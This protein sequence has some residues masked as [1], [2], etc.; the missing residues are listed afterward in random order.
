MAD[1]IEGGAR[2]LHRK[3]ARE[4]AGFARG[5]ESEVMSIAYVSGLSQKLVKRCRGGVSTARFECEA[6]LSEASA[7]GIYIWRA[8]GAMASMR[9]ACS[10][11]LLA[12]AT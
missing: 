5:L 4:P 7:N 1:E 2:L 9:A 3:Y 10:K 6:G 8:F 11:R 12:I